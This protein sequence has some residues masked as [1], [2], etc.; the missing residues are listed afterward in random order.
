M[1][2]SCGIQALAVSA[3]LALPLIYTERLPLHL[4][5]RLVTQAPPPAPSGPLPQAHSSGRATSN[6]TIDNRM[7]APAEV[8]R[9]IAQIDEQTAPPPVDLNPGV[10]GGIG[11]RRGW[12]SVVSPWGNA[13]N[14]VVLSPSKPAP[15]PRVS[16]IM[17]GNLIYRVQPQYPPLARQARIQGSVVLQAVISR[18]G[19]I[20]K[21]QVLSGHPML[22]Q[23]A[24]EA[25]RHWRYR[26]Y[27]LNGEPVEVET[28]VTVNFVLSEQ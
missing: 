2:A 4:T 18:E 19:A 10:R 25:V 8:P 16:H 17:E 15:T 23:A 12:N 24:V 9:N 5:S 28:E 22:V 13:L 21:L 6:L 1:L 20:E 7:V 11:D 27:V 3:L 14:P 26:P